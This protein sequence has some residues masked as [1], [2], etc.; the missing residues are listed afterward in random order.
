M[1]RYQISFTTG[2]VIYPPKEFEGSYTD[3]KKFAEA[4]L[5]HHAPGTRYHIRIWRMDPVYPTWVPCDEQGFPE[6]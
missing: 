4:Q 3:A 1:A 6:C 5:D 2:T